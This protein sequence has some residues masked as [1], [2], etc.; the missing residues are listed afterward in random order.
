M[1]RIGHSLADKD[2]KR[3]VTDGWVYIDTVAKQLYE[4]DVAEDELKLYKN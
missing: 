2:G 3:F 4:Y 1:Y